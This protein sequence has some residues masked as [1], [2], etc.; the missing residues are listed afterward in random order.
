M[1]ILLVH[2]VAGLYR[3]VGADQPFLGVAHGLDALLLALVADFPGLF[4]TVLGVAVLLGLLRA[5]LHLKLT[6]L[7][8]FEMAV[9]LLHWEGKDV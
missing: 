2:V 4:L 8:R 7:L 3:L 6:D 5:S 1:A 9:L